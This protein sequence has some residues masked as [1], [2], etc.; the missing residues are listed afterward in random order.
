MKKI[1]LIGNGAR[2]HVIAETFKR[3]PQECELAVYAKATNPALKALATEYHVTTDLSDFDTL[4]DF[5][6]RFRPDFAFIGPENP[7][8][9]GIVDFLNSMDIPCIGPTQALAQLECSKSFT[10]DLLSKYEIPGNPEFKVFTKPEGIAEFM[11]SLEGNYVV[12]ADTLQGGKGVKVSGEHLESIEEGTDFAIKCIEEDGRVVVEEK[13]VG[14][15]FSLICFS[16][17][18][19]LAP[20]PVAQD[21]KRAH[22]NDTGPN[23]GGMGAYTD[24]NH[25]LPFMTQSDFDQAMD[26]TQKVIEALKEET[27]EAYKGIIYGGFFATK[28]GVKLIEYNARFGDP[29]AQNM[30]ALLKTDLIQVCEAVIAGTL[31][32]INVE[33]EKKATVLKYLVPE[34]YPENPIKNKQIDMTPLPDGARA[35]FASID[36]R[37]GL[38]YLLGSR[39]VA[40]LGIA[41]SL[42]EAERIAQAAVETVKGPVFYR[43]DIGTSLLIQKRIDHMSELRD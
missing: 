19:S 15:E 10:R 6:G 23:T 35:Y 1:L 13:F 14:E 4:R 20:C 28:N 11:K 42:E 40:M 17:G 27:G 30:L 9:D 25:L 24:S 21:H 22:E 34:G 12:K 3:S 18:E 26:I 32:E 8:A 2:E 5:A 37:E 41:D 31:S 16:D 36:E 43:K 39:A 33:F 38:L 7:L 29:E